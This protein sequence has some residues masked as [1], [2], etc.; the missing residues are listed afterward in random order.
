M[1]ILGIDQSL[2]KCAMVVMNNYGEV[3]HKEVVRT[4]NVATKQKKGVTYFDSL[5]Q[6]IHHICTVMIK[7]VDTYKPDYIVFEALS[8]GSA[9]NA[10]RNLAQLFGALQETLLI[11][12]F[13]GNVSTVTPTGL[14]SF[15]RQFLPEKDQFSGKTKAG[16]PKL[17]KMDKKFMCEAV[18]NLFGEGYL[19][20]YNNTNGKDDVADATFLAYHKHKELNG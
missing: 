19:K 9:G 14:K 10:T 6:Q 11:N 20:E 5:E 7:H 13:K 16:K 2:A 18:D 15:A 12:D 3:I 1:T 8:F 17:V 4:G